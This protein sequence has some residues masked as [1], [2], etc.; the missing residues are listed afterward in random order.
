MNLIEDELKQEFINAPFPIHLN[1]DEM[2]NL[3]NWWLSRLSQYHKAK[4][5]EL[6]KRVEGMISTILP[7]LVD[8]NEVL[9]IIR[10]EI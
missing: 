5:E 7:G 8:K 10:E 6:K 9:K 2:N 4:M 3:A 1:D